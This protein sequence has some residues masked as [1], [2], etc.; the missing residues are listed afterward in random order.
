MG[1]KNCTNSFIKSLPSVVALVI[2]QDSH[3]NHIPLFQVASHTNYIHLDALCPSRDLSSFTNIRS[4]TVHGL[5]IEKPQL[6]NYIRPANF[7][8]LVHLTVKIVGYKMW[9]TYTEYEAGAI[10]GLT[11][12]IF[13]ED[14]F[15]QLTHFSL[16]TPYTYLSYHTHNYFNRTLVSLSLIGNTEIDFLA[17][18]EA[19]PNLHSLKVNVSFP[20]TIHGS[21]ID[22]LHYPP[23]PNER[24]RQLTL[25]QTELHF[26]QIY[27]L[28]EFIPQLT[29][30]NVI[31]H[32]TNILRG[33]G[34]LAYE[35]SSKLPHLEQFKCHLRIMASYSSYK[36][37]VD[38]LRKEHPLLESLF[39]EEDD[40]GEFIRT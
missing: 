38:N 19:A 22:G 34:G 24:L 40:T 25:V 15:S 13:S 30:L 6:L 33:F 29:H 16:E 27:E 8:H 11:D 36:K 2:G 23:V 37:V 17:F 21:I 18:L 20:T 39:V 10:T 7:P 26:Y 1:H 32:S 28:F 9:G 3:Q 31:A 12:I 35:L 4:L 5:N 14:A